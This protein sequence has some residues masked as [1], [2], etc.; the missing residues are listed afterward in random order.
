M[1]K[2]NTDFINFVELARLFT[3]STMSNDEIY[4][5]YISIKPNVKK[6]YIIR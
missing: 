6:E 3:G 1:I 4:Y 2:F 5:K